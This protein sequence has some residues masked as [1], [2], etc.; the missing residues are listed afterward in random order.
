MDPGWIVT[1]TENSK[2]FRSI[3]ARTSATS[4]IGMP[5]NSTGAPG[6]EPSHRVLEDE[7]IGLRIARRRVK[8]LGPIGVKGEDRV[9]LGRRQD[10]IRR[11]GLERDT[12]Y[13]NRQ[14]RLGLHSKTAGRER[15]V[16]SARMPEARVRVDVLVIG[17]LHEH[18]DGQ[19]LAVLVER[20]GRDLA[21]L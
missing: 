15:H 17:R 12:T 8:G 4:P 10:Q 1:G 21:D 13:K 6:V 9:L 14:Y 20:I 2:V 3:C 5:R 19:I 18:L 16:D 11:R 7:L